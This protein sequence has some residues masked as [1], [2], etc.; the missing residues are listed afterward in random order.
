MKLYIGVNQDKTCIISKQPLKR[1][2]DAETNKR[3]VFSF[4]DTKQ[5]PHWMLD[6]S[7]IEVGK[8]GDT[9]IDRYLTLPEGSINK[10][11]SISMTWEDEAK[12]IEL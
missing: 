1:F 11:F 4:R 8:Q 7:G 2:F 12:V 3:D 9:P 5:P 10:M 6:Y